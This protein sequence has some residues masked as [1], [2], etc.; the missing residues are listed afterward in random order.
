MFLVVEGQR[1]VGK[2]TAIRELTNLM[3]IR[4]FKDTR[5]ENVTRQIE[6]LFHLA[7]IHVSSAPDIPFVLDRFYITEYVM[8]K[9][10]ATYPRFYDQGMYSRIL[11]WNTKLHKMGGLTAILKCDEYHRLARLKETGKN[12]EANHK[13]IRELWAEAADC[14]ADLVID[15]TRI[16]PKDI[17]YILA[18]TLLATK[19][20]REL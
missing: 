12:D 18:S 7:R 8:R 11:D 13:T 6:R 2:T 20:R 15:T 1:G 4:P 14:W 5:G 10:E 17:A 3:A 9:S 16:E 19:Q